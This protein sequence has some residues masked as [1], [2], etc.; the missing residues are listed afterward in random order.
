MKENRGDQ[1]N[2]NQS[3][4]LTTGALSGKIFKFKKNNQPRNT[5]NLLC[6]SALSNKNPFTTN[7]FNLDGDQTN[8]LSASNPFAPR[9]RKIAEKP[10]KVLDA[11]NLS[12]DFYLNLVDW[13]Q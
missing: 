1:A 4:P 12:D 10:Y 3:K 5:T 2:T 6:D 13:S 7:F 11:P 8:Q 9:G